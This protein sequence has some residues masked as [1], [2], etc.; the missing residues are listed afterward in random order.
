MTLETTKVHKT[1]QEVMWHKLP[2]PKL[3]RKRNCLEFRMNF[4]QVNT[5]LL[6]SR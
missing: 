6:K 5:A 3:Y 1:N 4:Y 2:V